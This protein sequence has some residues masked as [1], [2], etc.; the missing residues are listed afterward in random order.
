MSVSRVACWQDFQTARGKSD[1]PELTLVNPRCLCAIKWEDICLIKTCQKQRRQMEFTVCEVTEWVIHHV[2]V[3]IFELEHIWITIITTAR[4]WLHVMI[5][6]RLGSQQFLPRRLD[7]FTCFFSSCYIC[8]WWSSVLFQLSVVIIFVFKLEDWKLWASVVYVC[9]WSTDPDTHTRRS[10][11][12][13]L[14]RHFHVQQPD[15]LVKMWHTVA[16]PGAEIQ[17]HRAVSREISM[18]LINIS[19]LIDRTSGRYKGS[20]I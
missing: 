16:P 4:L 2:L 12:Q 15:R 13:T 8:M 19:T 3:F 18:N 17:R 1:V 7:P 5:R 10:C 14:R 11:W 9:V 6:M 20:K